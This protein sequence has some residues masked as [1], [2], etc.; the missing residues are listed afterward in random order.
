M[1]KNQKEYKAFLYTLDSE[2]PILTSY[3]TIVSKSRIN[4]YNTINYKSYKFCFFSHCWLFPGPK[5]SLETHIA[6]CWNHLFVS[7]K[8]GY[9]NS[10]CL[11]WPFLFDKYWPVLLY[12]VC[13]F[14]FISWAFMIKFRLW[15]FHKNITEIMYSSQ[16]IISRDHLKYSETKI[17]AHGFFFLHLVC[18]YLQ[19]LSVDITGKY[20]CFHILTSRSIY[21]C[22]YIIHNLSQ[23]NWVH[24]DISVFNPTLWI[25]VASPFSYI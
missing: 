24:T 12:S 23:I 7:F 22:L 20:T 21:V 6:Y 3:I 10:I 2:S 8:L 18:H 11:S 16:C 5:S 19:S 17:W 4:W 1:I 13:H 25:L 9:I 15:I 14:R